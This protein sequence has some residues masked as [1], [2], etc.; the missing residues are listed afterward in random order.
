MRRGKFVILAV[1]DYDLGRPGPGDAV[2]TADAEPS[3]W[4][5][6]AVGIRKIHGL[7][8]M[9]AG[10]SGSSAT[11]AIGNDDPGAIIIHIISRPLHRGAGSKGISL[12]R[13]HKCN[14]RCRAVNTGCNVGRGIGYAA[15]VAESKKR[16]GGVRGLN[17]K[18]A[19][20]ASG[21]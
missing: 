17:F 6:I 21:H 8:W 15:R 20:G 13:P 7:S 9:V 12:I 3:L 16:K 2:G 14:V 18:A 1:I 19:G 5:E 10:L 11:R 4:E